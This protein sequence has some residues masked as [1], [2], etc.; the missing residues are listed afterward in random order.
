[1][2]EGKEGRLRRCPS[3]ANEKYEMIYGKCSLQA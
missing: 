3:I 2:I 1:M